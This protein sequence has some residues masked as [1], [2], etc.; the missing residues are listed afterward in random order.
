VRIVRGPDGRIELGLG[1]TAEL[2]SNPVELLLTDLLAPPDPDRAMGFLKRVSVVGADLTL[3]DRRLGMSWRAPSA[4]VSFERDGTGIAATGFLDLEVGGHAALFDATARYNSADG[5][6][7][8][9]VNFA[10]VQPEWF[11]RDAPNLALLAAGRFPVGGSVDIEFG[12]GARASRID[13]DLS[14]GAGTLAIG[15][16]F[17]HGFDMTFAQARGQI[18]VA[19]QR[20]RLDDFFVDFGGPKVTA[21]GLF[22]GFGRPPFVAGDL[23]V[24]DLPIDQVERYWPRGVWPKFRD[25]I[26]ANRSG[27][28]IRRAAAGVHIQPPSVSSPALP[29]EVV[30]TSID[31]EVGGRTARLNARLRN[32]GADGD[33][34]AHVEFTDMRPEWFAGTSPGLATLAGAQVPVRG[35][36]DVMLGSDGGVTRVGFDVAAGAGDLALEEWFDNSFSVA[37]AQAKGVLEVGPEKLR[38]DDVYIDLGGPKLALQGWVEGFNETPFIAAGATATDLPIDDLALYWPRD[39]WQL[40]RQWLDEN[41]SDGFVRKAQANIHLRPEDQTGEGIPEEALRIGI[42]AEGVTVHY[43][44]PL[45]AVVALNGIGTITGSTVD[46][47]MS[48]GR[49][50]GLMVEEARFKIAGLEA[51]APAVVDVNFLGPLRD[52]MELLAHPYLGYAQEF[53]IDPALVGGTARA[54]MRFAFPLG[55]E[56]VT[57]AANA[58]L[59]DVEMPGVFEGYDLSRGALALKLDAQGMDVGGSI[60]L[61]GVPATG[62]WHENFGPAAQYRSR[63]AVRGRF[64][65]AQRLLLGIPGNEW[66]EGP[67][68]VDIDII[69]S[70]QGRRRWRATAELRD[71]A[72]QLPGIRWR[73]DPGTEGILQLEGRSAP[74]NTMTISRIDVSAGDLSASGR[75]E[76]DLGGGSLK[77]LELDYLE[78]GSTSV[79]ATMAPMAGAGY[80]INLTG[81]RVDLRP[82]LDDDGRDPDAEEE[83]LPPLTL[84]A[85]LGQVIISDGYALR[86]VN[87]VLDRRKNRWDAVTTTAKLDND[88]RFALHVGAGDGGR[89]LQVTADDAGTV[90]RAFDIFDN[91]IGGNLLLTAALD[92]P[93]EPNTVTG[94]LRIDDHRLLNAPLLA[95]VLSVASLT[96]IFELLKGEGLP[97]RRLIAPFTKRGDVIEVSDARSYGSALGIT[98]KGRIDLANEAVD[99]DGTLVPAYAINSALGFLPVIGDILVGPTGGGVFAATYRVSGRIEDPSI[100]VNPLAALAP[101]VLRKLFQFFEGRN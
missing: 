90:L 33:V 35:T 53:D 17:D 46:L 66:I 22:E 32:G 5:T 4:T 74:G 77:S 91:M 38:L 39:Q 86:D 41:L 67:A 19:T 34:S 65:D 21:Q 72:V 52:V 76:I 25:W 18:D 11:A 51:G 27:G 14:A 23:T 16:W 20:L 81:D 101:G 45:P 47:M 62:S 60:R 79:E 1:E 13:F 68:N 87:A 71:A 28:V 73:K 43:L 58:N 61:N 78:F 96:G 84:T 40:T 98:M 8:M 89:V 99:L 85:L 82:Y 31:L 10:D 100:T 29:D 69:D 42:E 49:L 56:D 95:K 30:K 70:D 97:F 80:A 37:S 3:V 9:R 2:A 57:V 24:T 83:D 54:Q 88:S 64:T 55:S 94:K 36:L 6:I 63:F 12:A 26:A 59:G 75:A 15:E 44:R 93:G 92:T 48:S 7:T 50:K